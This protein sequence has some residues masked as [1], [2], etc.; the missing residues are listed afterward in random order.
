M[1]T[2]ELVAHYSARLNDSADIY[3]GDPSP[4][5]AWALLRALALARMHSV[6]HA[7]YDPIVSALSPFAGEILEAALHYGLDEDYAGAVNEYAER[8]DYALDEW[9]DQADGFIILHFELQAIH[10]WVA[11]RVLASDALLPRIVKPL[12]AFGG[13]VD[14]LRA[15]IG[16]HGSLFHVGFALHTELLRHA[17][18]KLLT[19]AYVLDCACPQF[20]SE[21]L[22]KEILC[23]IVN[24]VAG[25]PE[26]RRMYFV[27]AP[28]RIV[29]HVFSRNDA[30][31]AVRRAGEARSSAAGVHFIETIPPAI[32]R[33][34]DPDAD[35]WDDLVFWLTS[36]VG[37]PDV[38]NEIARRYLPSV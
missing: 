3:E 32:S 12:E 25:S 13:A 23:E 8:A 14:R 36:L 28:E 22:V 31:K 30:E 9:E 1:V 2:P 38:A 10:D 24:T 7:V 26:P 19:M 6:P 5:S 37:N 16:A 35:E 17:D 33:D 29:T 27:R 4:E 21:Y 34:A 20:F 15:A 11:D 18:P